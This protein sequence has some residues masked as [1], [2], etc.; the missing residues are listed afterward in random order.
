MKI[1]IKKEAKV[2]SNLKA[3]KTHAKYKYTLMFLICI[4]ANKFHGKDKSHSK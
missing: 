3:N 1:K 2:K 4:L